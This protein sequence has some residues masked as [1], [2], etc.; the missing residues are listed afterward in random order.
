MLL[1]IIGFSLLG[2]IGA[3]AGAGLFLFFPEKIRKNLVPCLVSF[4]IGTLLGAAFLGM[5]PA[6]L[7]QAPAIVIMMTV[8]A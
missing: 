5:I 6:G 3:L 1:W 4:A 8:L 2:S 7:E